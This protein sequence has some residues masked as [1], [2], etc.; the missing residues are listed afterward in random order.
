MTR[1]NPKRLFLLAAVP[2][3]TFFLFSETA[4]A[5]NE[6]HLKICGKWRSQ[7]TDGQVNADVY[8]SNSQLDRPALYAGYTILRGTTVVISGYL[9]GNGCTPYFDAEDGVTY[10]IQQ[11]SKFLRSTNR[12]VYVQPVQSGPSPIFN[13]WF[14]KFQK[15]Y[16]PSGHS[17]GEYDTHDNYITT[18][19]HSQLGPIVGQMLS[20]ANALDIPSSTI[21]HVVGGDSFGNAAYCGSQNIRFSSFPQ[22]KFQ[23]GHEF[24]HAIGDLYDVD[25]TGTNCRSYVDT[26]NRLCRRY[27]SS[28]PYGVNT[29]HVLQA[30]ELIEC[31][32]EEG[33]AHFIS[34]VIFNNRDDGDGYFGAYYDTLMSESPDVV[35]WAPWSCDVYDSV[36]WDEDICGANANHGAEWDW[37]TFFWQIWDDGEQINISQIHDLWTKDGDPASAHYWTNILSNASTEL[38]GDEYDHFY[39]MG[40]DNGV[41]H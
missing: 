7:Y 10:K 35:V 34:T 22:K 1:F 23:M 3:L 28:D 38:N 24:G 4:F 17:S 25:L 26:T 5:G 36:K 31:A 21:F 33:F 9:D 12:I 11:H 32:E 29:K 19:F 40:D 37:L 16:T 8:D 20:K 2:A 27:V 18:S 14:L 13:N 41:N 15:Y 30:S 6:F 39:Y